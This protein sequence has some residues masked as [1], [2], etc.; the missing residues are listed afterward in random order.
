[1]QC[2]DQIKYEIGP[3]IEVQDWHPHPDPQVFNKVR[4]VFRCPLCKV[5]TECSKT[6]EWG[7]VSVGSRDEKLAMQRMIDAGCKHI[8]VASENKRI[9]PDLFSQGADARRGKG[10]KSHAVAGRKK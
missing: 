9:D 4:K 5:T 1:M 8:R 3:E 10:G 2:L 6:A 7:N